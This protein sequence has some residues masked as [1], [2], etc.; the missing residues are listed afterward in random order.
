MDA[1]SNFKFGIAYDDLRA[2]G[3]MTHSL[4]IIDARKP[5][6]WRH[7]FRPSNAPSAELA[8]KVRERF[9]WLLDGSQ[10]T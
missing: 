10:Q 4:A 1:R 2:A 3:D 7:K 9:G 6:H 8:R 5:Y